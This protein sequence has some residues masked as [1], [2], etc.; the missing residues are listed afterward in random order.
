[1]KSPTCVLFWAY[2][3]LGVHVVKL[4]LSF[5]FNCGLDLVLHLNPWSI[6]S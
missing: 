3:L 1:M 5:F 2:F 6:L 4:L